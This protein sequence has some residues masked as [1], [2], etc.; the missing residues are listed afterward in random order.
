MKDRVNVNIDHRIKKMIEDLKEIHGKSWTE[1][2]EKAA[3]ELLLE[4]D[5]VE[6]LE[7]LIKIEDEK[8]NERRENLI[9]TKANIEILK[10]QESDQEKEEKEREEQ[11]QKH[12]L[13]IFEKE[14]KSL[15]NQWKNG[16]L[17]W[18]R[19]IDFGKFNDMK[20]A[21]WWLEKELKKRGIMPKNV[22]YFQVIS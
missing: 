17:N 19:I 2:L 8:Q 5:P 14:F 10:L 22:H 4:I 13:E 11:L 7:Y 15:E 9:R 18:T 3:I 6:S 20:E 1:L 16:R 21:K 12:R